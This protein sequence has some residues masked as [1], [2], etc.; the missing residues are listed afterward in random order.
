MPHNVP[1]T[2]GTNAANSLPPTLIIPPR[3]Q[4]LPSSTS[5]TAAGHHSGM[6]PL[7]LGSKDSATSPSGSVTGASNYFGA[8]PD[9]A[10]VVPTP[11]SPPPQ[12]NLAPQSTP[13]F[14]PNAVPNAA[15][16]TGKSTLA[17]PNAST[18]SHMPLSRESRISLPDEAK[19]YIANMGDSPL[20]SPRMAG[21]ADT[22][23]D[24]DSKDSGERDRGLD[25]VA[26][27]VNGKYGRAESPRPFLE[28][29]DDES[30][31]E[32]PAREGAGGLHAAES[33]LEGED[34]EET[35]VNLD[36]GSRGGEAH[37]QKVRKA[38]ATADQFPLPPA[39]RDPLSP[40]SANVPS[41]PSQSASSPVYSSNNPFATNTT[42]DNN[43]SSTTK[44][45]RKPRDSY[46][47]L[48][49]DPPAMTFR[50]LPLLAKDLE[51]AEV[52]VIGSNIRAN[53]KGK[54]RLSFVITVHVVGKPEL[55]VRGVLPFDIVACPCKYVQALTSFCDTCPLHSS[56]ST[57][58]MSYFLTP[59]L[60]RCAIEAPSRR[61]HLCRTPSYSRITHLRRLIN[62]RSVTITVLSP[63]RYVLC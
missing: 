47:T 8:P 21:S 63:S 32:M 2:N 27:E 15:T 41:L 12:V 26:E 3:A 13:S 4:S 9:A 57:T 1:L 49:E 17:L 29:E 20:P 55:K 28:L 6:R 51:K 43:P 18:A 52:N 56:R 30:D 46:V 58:Q 60:G 22:T 59:S 16:L 54:E 31:G 38:A 48:R 19:R 45:D 11:I 23:P 39:T 7:H 5:P 33:D 50:S 61:L 10:R 62:A 14:T 44:R 36:Y 25:V 40:T 24:P 53:D 37:V 42:H 34:T 35:A